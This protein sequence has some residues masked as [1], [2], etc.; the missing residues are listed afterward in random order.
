MALGT[1]KGVA[2]R[3]RKNGKRDGNAENKITYYY[4]KITIKRC[5]KLDR[6]LQQNSQSE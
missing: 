2:D 4:M 5:W 1:E 6:I 3:Y